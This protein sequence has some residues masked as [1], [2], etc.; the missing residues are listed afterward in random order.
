MWRSKPAAMPGE[1]PPCAPSL[2][3]AF[4]CLCLLFTGGYWLYF[5]PTAT[6]SIDINPSIELGVNRFNRVVSVE[7]YN[8]DGVKLAGEL[9]V[10]YADY[11]DALNQVLANDTVAALLDADGV[12]TIT[13]VGPEGEQPPICWQ[14]WKP[15]P[16]TGKTPTAMPAPP[17]RWMRPMRRGSPMASTGLT[18]SCKPWRRTSPS[19]RPGMTMREIQELVQQLTGEE[20]ATQTEHADETSSGHGHGQ[21]GGRHGQ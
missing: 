16:P 5:T 10:Q 12:L 9:S 15:A 14:V 20:P 3:A 1:G 21:G 11:M 13:V 18:W 17:R 7:G 2:A 19:R 6:I 4:A 8:A